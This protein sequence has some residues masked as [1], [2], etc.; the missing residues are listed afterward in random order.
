MSMKCTSVLVVFS[1]THIILCLP[2][3]PFYWES[4]IVQACPDMFPF[5][6][7]FLILNI[8]EA[9]TINGAAAVTQ[10]TGGSNLSIPLDTAVKR[11]WSAENFTLSS[12]QLQESTADSLFGP[13]LSLPSVN[14]T[15]TTLLIC[16]GNTFGF[17]LQLQSCLSAIGNPVLD[18]RDTSERTWGPRGTGA[19]RVL[20]VRY[21]SRE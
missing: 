14:T 2:S 17:G 11:L 18:S 13:N 5:L 20:P 12:A 4:Y 10:H 3:G 15:V 8:V 9:L 19:S 1:F 16:N 21:V 7:I 6:S